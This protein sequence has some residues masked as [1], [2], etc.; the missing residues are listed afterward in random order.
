MNGIGI[1]GLAAMLVSWAMAA[2][3]FFTGPSQRQNRALAGFLLLQ[4]IV[5]GVGQGLLYLVDDPRAAYGLQVM[6]FAFAVPAFAAY[7]WFLSTLGTAIT[8]PLRHPAALALL[9]L[10]SGAW[11]VFVALRPELFVTGISSPWHYPYAMY[12][13]QTT[14]AFSLVYVLGDGICGLLGLAASILLLRNS[15]PGTSARRKAVLYALAFVVFDIFVALVIALYNVYATLNP[16][17]FSPLEPFLWIANAADVVFVLLLGYGILRAQ[18]FDIDVRLKLVVS[19]GTL[20]GIYLA[21]F[22]IVEQL[23]QGVVSASAG[24]IWGGIATGILLFALHPLQRMA[25]RV[26]DV[27]LPQVDDSAAYLDKRKAE[28]YRDAV[29]SLL[30]DGELTRKERIILDQL[31]DKLGLDLGAAHTIEGTAWNS[32]AAKA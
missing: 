9:G 25:S 31:R 6:S 26:A 32:V 8:R 4:S 1:I 19:R 14:Q 27:A 30:S 20:Y 13:G 17:D 24:I 22:L 3:V 7:L 15:L 16:N 2:L 5:H 12:E 10:V 11:V 18:L 23:V 21:V 28:V 29:E